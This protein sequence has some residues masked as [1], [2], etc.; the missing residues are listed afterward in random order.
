M[1]YYKKQALLALIPI[2]GF[3]IVLFSGVFK[4]KKKRGFWISWF[5][6]L[7]SM[8]PLF[9]MFLAPILHPWMLESFSVVAV[10]IISY[11]WVLIVFYIGAY[12]SIAIQKLF[13]K[14][15]EE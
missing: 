11:V 7:C 14:D 9:L 12:V 2:I 5:Q 8:I 13:L 3:F 4:V 6:G 15:P 10:K 1:N